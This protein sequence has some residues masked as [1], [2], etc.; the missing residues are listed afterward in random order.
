VKIIRKIVAFILVVAV[1]FSAVSKSF[2]LLDFLLNRDYI[3]KNLCEKR[4]IKDNCC[5][6]NCHL[7]K[8]MHEEEKREGASGI[9]EIKNEIVSVFQSISLLNFYFEFYQELN[10][11]FICYTLNGHHEKIFQPPTMG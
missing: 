7:K 9:T 3:S 6:G 2:L 10:C 4:A 8:Q 1:V 5:R 11:N